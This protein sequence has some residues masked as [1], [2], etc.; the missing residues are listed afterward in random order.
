MKSSLKE[1]HKHSSN[2][3]GLVKASESCGCFYCLTVFKPAEIKEWTDRGQTAIC[4]HCGI[5]SVLPD[6]AGVPLTDEFLKEMERAWF[7][8]A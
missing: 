4:P 1:A 2:H 7:A 6:K 8:D 3:A 5:D